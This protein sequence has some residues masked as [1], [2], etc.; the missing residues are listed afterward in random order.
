MEYGVKFMNPTP[1]PKSLAEPITSLVT[2]S[3]FQC[4]SHPWLRISI[5]SF[6]E[7]GAHA[8]AQSIEIQGPVAIG[9]LMEFCRQILYESKKY[10]ESLIKDPT[11]IGRQIIK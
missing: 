11:F 2:A 3:V 4:S 1:Q 8:P 7:E 5:A 9:K 6:E 10:E